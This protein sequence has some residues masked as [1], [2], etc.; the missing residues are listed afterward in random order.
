MSAFRLDLS[1]FQ[2]CFLLLVLLLVL[3]DFFPC[4]LSPSVR[5]F[6]LRSSVCFQTAPGKLSGKKLIGQ[7]WAT[8]PRSHR[9]GSSPVKPHG[10]DSWGRAG[11]CA[12]S[13]HLPRSPEKTAGNK[14]LGAVTL[15][16]VHAEYYPTLWL[17]FSSKLIIKTLEPM[18]V[19]DVVSG[20]SESSFWLIHI[21][22]VK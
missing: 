14:H 4:R 17:V 22:S 13:P 10:V 5:K 19:L 6:T 15:C 2:W 7:P 11:Q 9:E 21:D 16:Q 1:Y 20:L 12:N 8:C 18:C 3:L